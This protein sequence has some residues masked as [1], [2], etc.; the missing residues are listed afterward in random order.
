MPPRSLRTTFSHVSVASGVPSSEIRWRVRPP[1]LARSLWQPIQYL[2]TK[3]RSETGAADC[4]AVP[5]ATADG[6]AGSNLGATRVVS[7]RRSTWSIASA[8]RTLV[9]RAAA[10]NIVARIDTPPSLTFVTNAAKFYHAATWVHALASGP[11]GSANYAV[12][13]RLGQIK[14]GGRDDLP[15]PYHLP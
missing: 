4:T 9:E 6:S 5:A 1:V 12:R 13:G 11:D 14:L 2:S 15:R 7:H 10:V 3:A 8:P